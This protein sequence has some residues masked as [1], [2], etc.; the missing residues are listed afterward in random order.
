MAFKTLEEANEYQVEMEK[1]LQESKQALEGLQLKY[2][3]LESDFNSSNE[4]IKRLKIK[5]YEYL[6]QIPRGNAIQNSQEFKK[7]DEPEEKI[8]SINDIMNDLK[9]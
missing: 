9:I 8:I 4:E 3:S 1:K 6:E 7:V 2:E 5:N